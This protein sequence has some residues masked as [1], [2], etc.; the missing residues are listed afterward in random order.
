MTAPEGP[1]SGTLVVCDSRGVASAFVCVCNPFSSVLRSALR[2]DVCHVTVTI[3]P[4]RKH[5]REEDHHGE[6]AAA[7]MPSEAIHGKASQFRKRC[8]GGGTGKSGCGVQ[9]PRR[10][11]RLAAAAATVVAGGKVKTNAAADKAALLQVVKTTA[12]AAARIPEDGQ[13]N[14]ITARRM[15]TAADV[16][17][18]TSRSRKPVQESTNGNDWMKESSGGKENEG[19]QD[20]Q[21]EAVRDWELKE[22][23]RLMEWSLRSRCCSVAVIQQL[24]KQLQ[25]GEDCSVSV[26]VISRVLWSARVCPALCCRVC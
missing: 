13:G 3:T 1:T 20:I 4:G 19:K 10:S 11:S 21:S 2:P 7:G 26:E 14:A 25:T 5:E 17:R 9:S 15:R 6:E 24:L 22:V 12:M 18:A 23:L 8:G 16:G